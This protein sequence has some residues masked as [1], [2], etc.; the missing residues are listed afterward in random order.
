MNWFTEFNKMVS[1]SVCGCGGKT[2]LVNLLASE[3]RNKK[4]LITP[5]TKMRPLYD[6]D[7]QL[8]TTREMCISHA[9]QTGIQCMGI[10]NSS[11]NK[12]EA[13]NETD[14]AEVASQYDLVLMEA[15]GSRGLPCKGWTKQDPVIPNFTTHT[16]GVVSIHALGLPATEANVYRLPEFL[17]LTGLHEQDPITLHALASMID[18]KYGMFHRYQGQLIVCINQVESA[19]DRQHAELLK[20][21]ILEI[22]PYP[23]RIIIGSA[24]QNCFWETSQ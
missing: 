23:I 1:V 10:L 11:T 13:L 6:D 24:K 14:L 7:I 3:Y 22:Y 5:T 15:D 4:V 17:T 2:S 8:C 20:K 16:I 19:Q 21:L 9:A 12:L 18:F